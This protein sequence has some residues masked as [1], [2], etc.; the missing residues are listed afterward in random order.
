MWKYVLERCIWMIAVSLIVALIIFTILYFIPGTPA[1]RLL[2][3]GATREEIREMEILLGLDKPY[4]VQLGVFLFNAF[5]GKI[6]VMPSNSTRVFSGF[7]SNTTS[8]PGK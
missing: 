5:S 2:P 3:D 6:G 7:D 8:D 4:L 1:E